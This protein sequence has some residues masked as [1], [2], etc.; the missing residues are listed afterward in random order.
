MCV[1]ERLRKD[2]PRLLGYG[3][4]K[5]HD[6]K[7]I[8]AIPDGD[9]IHKQVSAHLGVLRGEKLEDVGRRIFN[10][11]GLA[12]HKDKARIAGYAAKQI[13]KLIRKGFKP[14]T[15]LTKVK[16]EP[17]NKGGNLCEWHFCLIRVARTI[18]EDVTGEKRKELGSV[19]PLN[20]IR[21]PIRAVLSS[22]G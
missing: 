13:N 16:R 15:D 10:R 17:K 5:T 7:Y 9:P 14:A 2:V 22:P 20:P 19:I 12:T 8:F 18:S 21:I 4:K 1:R 3:F 11:Q 6:G